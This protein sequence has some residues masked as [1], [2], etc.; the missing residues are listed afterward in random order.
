MSEEGRPEGSEAVRRPRQAG[1]CLT[2]VCAHWSGGACSQDG[3]C[4]VGGKVSGSSCV[5][6]CRVGAARPREP[7]RPRLH[8]RQGPCLHTDVRDAP[9]LFLS[10]KLEKGRHKCPCLYLE[11]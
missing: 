11:S 2:A 3:G 10:L 9:T 8:P 1:V 7:Q 4:R 5:E 6:T